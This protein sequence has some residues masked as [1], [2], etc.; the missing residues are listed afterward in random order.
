MDGQ[1]KTDGD[2]LIDYLIQT[3]EYGNITE[4]AEGIS[5]H[6]KNTNGWQV[7]YSNMKWE[8]PDNEDAHRRGI[9]TF[10]RRSTPYPSFLP[11]DATSREVCISRRTTTNTPLQALVTLNDPVYLEAA[12]ALAEDVSRMDMNQD[13]RLQEAYFRV[14]GK[15]ANEEKIE[16]L[17]DLYTETLNHYKESPDEAAKLVEE[18][19]PEL[20][21]YTLVV[22]SLMNLDEF[23][24]KN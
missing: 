21:S 2:R 7:V 1:Y 11:F 20:A 10:L 19:N 3:L 12:K 23:I 16:V 22:N 15:N 24:M 4:A 13:D 5:G 14:V 8:T 17:R 6:P 9:Y 18:E